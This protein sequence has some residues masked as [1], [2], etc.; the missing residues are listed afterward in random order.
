MDSGSSCEVI[1]EHCFLILK[2]SIRALRVDFKIPL[3]GFSREHPWPL[4]EKMGIVVSTIHETI[5]FHTPYGIGIVSSTYESNKDEEGKKKG[6]GN[7]SGGYE[8]CAQ[9]CR[10]EGKDQCE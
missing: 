10:R 6:Q 4:R 7:P 5:K 3:V 1:Y 9:L 8:G 2:P